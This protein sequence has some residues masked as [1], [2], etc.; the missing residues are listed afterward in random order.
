MEPTVLKIAMAGLLH[1]IGK[2]AQGCLEVTPEYLNNNANYQPFNKKSGRHTHIHAVYTAA[3]I[4]QFADHLPPQWNMGG[5][6]DGDSFLNLASGHHNPQ[7]PM[8]W[9]I[10]AADR[11]SSGFDRDSFDQGENIK[12]SEFRQT[13]LL[14]LLESLTVDD[15]QQKKYADSGNFHFRYPLARL[16]PETIFP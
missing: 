9:I 3:F 1:D 5:W 12:I 7:T 2:F 6:G 4:E 11:I 8:Q 15:E 16:A 13:R 14:P 10:A